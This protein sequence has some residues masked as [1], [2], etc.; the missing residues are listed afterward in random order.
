MIA[1]EL[2][3]YR[4]AIVGLFLGFSSIILWLT[5]AGMNPL[6]AAAQMGIF[7]FV[8]AMIMARGVAEAGLLMTETSFLPSHLINLVYP[9]PQLGAQNLSML[10]MTNII[11]TRD[12]RGVLLSPLLD[13]QKMAGEL[14][15]RQRALLLPL[16]LAVVIAY[17]VASYFFLH[18]HY[19]MGGLSLNGYPSANAQWMFNLAKSTIQGGTTLPDATAYGGFG[20]GII[21]TSLMVWMRTMFTW[22]PFHPL[23]YALGPTWSMI[24]LWFPFFMAWVI[25]GAVLRFGGVDSYR[26]LMPFMLGLIL[27]EF[28][29][30]VFW[31]LM[32]MWRGWSTPS[33]PWQ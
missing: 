31:A 26:K 13:D 32:N 4:T 28:S 21:V 12:L 20:V 9:M 33:F 29:T 30:A 3:S 16:A 11:F 17:I 5:L 2:M 15:V 22:F 14:R 10:A 7:I 18:Y 25:K 24:V 23:A 8:V 27:G 1:G 6:L 19:S